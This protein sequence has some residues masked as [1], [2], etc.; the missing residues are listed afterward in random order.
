LP[1]GR[2]LV[3]N[4]SSPIGNGS[5][6]DTIPQQAPLAFDAACDGPR[7]VPRRSLAVR[8]AT[9]RDIASSKD[10]APFRAAVVDGALEGIAGILEAKWALPC[11]FP[12]F[13]SRGKRES[14]NGSD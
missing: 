6:N 12:A 1:A 5:H 8:V 10:R 3:Q 4:L 13:H 11:V 14:G 7:R 9:E 2:A